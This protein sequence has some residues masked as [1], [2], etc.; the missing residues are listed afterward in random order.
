MEF[1]KHCDNM[2]YITVTEEDQMKLYCKNCN[3]SSIEADDDATNRHV[4]SHKYSPA[5]DTTYSQ[6]CISSVN[7]NIDTS[8]YRQYMT[9]L[10]KYDM[11]LPRVN[12][13]D[14]PK[15]CKTKDGGHSEVIYIKY[16]HQNMK[17][18]YFCCECEEFWKLE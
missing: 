13:I 3:Y 5:D 8:S 12:N 10:I 15:G 11:T 1:C 6:K 16:D 7:Y 17:Y 18:L 2:L 4:T 9:P 14:C